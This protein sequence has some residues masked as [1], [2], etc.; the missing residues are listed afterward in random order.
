VVVLVVVVVVV[1]VVMVVVVVMMVVVV[2]V[3]IMVM[4][5]VV[6]VVVVASAGFCDFVCFTY[7]NFFG[8]WTVYRVLSFCFVSTKR[9][10]FPIP[11][12]F[13]SF[14]FGV[15]PCNLFALCNSCYSSSS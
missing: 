6:V 15:A 2:M 7:C 4:V 12:L 14:S 1:E 3:I 11:V 8:F 9:P 13:L 10:S 5:V